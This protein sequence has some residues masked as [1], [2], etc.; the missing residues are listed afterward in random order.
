MP[1]ISTHAPSKRVRADARGILHPGAP[2]QTPP[3][4]ADYPTAAPLQGTQR[5]PSRPPRLTMPARARMRVSTR[6]SR[7]TCSSPDA[8]P[9]LACLTAEA[10][11]RGQRSKRPAPYQL[12]RVGRCIS[13]NAVGVSPVW[14]VKKV[15]KLEGSRK[16]SWVAGRVFD[17]S[18]AERGRNGRRRGRSRSRVRANHES[19]P[20]GRSGSGEPRAHRDSVLGSGWRADGA[21]FRSG[22][23]LPGERWLLVVGCWQAPRSC[24]QPAASC[25]RR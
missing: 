6:A 23:P 16:P 1:I 2:Q 4:P 24:G 15:A 19:R 25:A 22:R 18:S 14:C 10:D 9:W 13:R 7:R 3:T 11:L 21:A 8:R 12:V 5:R 17:W 20:R